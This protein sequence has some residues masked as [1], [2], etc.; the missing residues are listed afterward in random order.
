MCFIIQQTKKIILTTEKSEYN[1]QTNPYGYRGRPGTHCVITRGTGMDKA[2]SLITVKVSMTFTDIVLDGGN[3]EVSAK[4]A[5]LNT[6]GGSMYS[7]LELGENALLQNAKTSQDGGAV[8]LDYGNFA[9]TGCVIRN[10]TASKNGGGVYM[11]SCTKTG[12]SRGYMY[13]ES[14]SISG[15]NAA[16]G[17]GIFLT[18]G[19]T[20][21]MSGGSVSGCGAVNGAGLYVEKNT[22]NLDFTNY[23]N[24]S[25]GSIRNNTATGTGGGIGIDTNVPNE[26]VRLNFSGR[27]VVSG[28][29][30]NGAPCNV[31]LDRDTNDVINVTGTGLQNG[32]S[33]GVFVPDGANFYNKHGDKGLPFGK[34]VNSADT[35]KLYCFTNDRNGLKGGLKAG[36]D[37]NIVYW[38]E[39]FTLEFEKHL[40][41]SAN[42][43]ENISDSEIFTFEVTLSGDAEVDG[44]KDAEEFVGEQGAVTFV[45]NG[46]DSVK[47]TV[48]MTAED[49]KEGRSLVIIPGL[50]SGLDYRITEEFTTPQQKK[51]AAF[52]GYYTGKIG[53]NNKG[54]GTDITNRYTSHVIFK[55]L[56]PVCKI[57]DEN[58]TLRY[59]NY[60]DSK[61]EVR[62]VPW[63]R[64][65][66]KTIWLTRM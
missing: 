10:C 2:K 17:G 45:A 64:Q 39:I 27:P 4:G 28:N 33:I 57:T 51:Y 18:N 46:T 24:M 7:R 3:I 20:I 38:I 60:T 53:E 16:K 13:F 29:T 21:N 1:R 35:S 47:A 34:Y 42:T 52:P 58:G 9:L 40:E 14:G 30:V 31:R 56:L 49:V 8:Y 23:F 22:Q 26:R 44:Q 55:N 50:S 66:G 63:L 36:G 5:L 11:A 6:I 61:G 62:R 48:T 32:A 54:G 43:V 37:P 59:Q 65:C 41:Y 12:P 25:G 19:G 15:C